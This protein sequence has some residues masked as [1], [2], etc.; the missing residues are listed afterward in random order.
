MA[1]TLGAFRRRVGRMIRIL[2]TA[3]TT[4]GGAATFVAETLLDHFPNDNDLNGLFVYDVDAENWR[5][6]IDWIASTFTGTVNRNFDD[7]ISAE[8]IEIYRSFD[9]DEID[10]AIT[11]ALVEV[12]SYIATIVV[13]T[14][15][16][17]VAN[18]HEYTI[19][20]SIR[21]LERMR[22]G[23]VEYEMVTTQTTYPYQKIL[24]WTTRDVRTV[25]GNNTL[26]I[27]PQEEVPDGRTIRLIGLGEISL[28]ANDAASFAL[29]NDQLRLLAWKVAEILYRDYAPQFSGKEQKFA[30][31]RAGIYS[32]L[33]EVNKDRMAA[34]L[35]PENIK[36][37]DLSVGVVRDLAQNTPVAG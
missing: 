33:F 6:V 11:D 14:S 26:L 27:P 22:G 3:T 30:A 13:D 9:P 5:L 23:I 10:D 28:P 20:S 18:Q 25:S 7:A 2:T 21:D 32:Q 37:A 34:I 15:L 16:S 19:P 8:A 36:A 29:E 4:S 17:G 31:A 12:Y 1:E 24:G 35:I